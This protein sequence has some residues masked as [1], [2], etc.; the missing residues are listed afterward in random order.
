MYISH[1]PTEHLF[2]DKIIK[3]K[4]KKDN[5]RIEIQ[6]NICWTPVNTKYQLNFF[7]MKTENLQC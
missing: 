1:C 5:V 6:W 3:R 2:P 4:Q 7:I